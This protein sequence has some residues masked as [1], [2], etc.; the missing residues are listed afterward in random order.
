ALL[1][2]QSGIVAMFERSA[3][4]GRTVFGP[5][6]LTATIGGIRS[7][8]MHGTVVSATVLFALA[9]CQ[10]HMLIYSICFLIGMSTDLILA[11]RNSIIAVP[12][13]A[14]DSKPKVLKIIE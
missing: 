13:E 1:A 7:A 6:D 4:L 11:N 8:L 9:L 12:Q 2:G 5:L 3:E 14:F 10:R